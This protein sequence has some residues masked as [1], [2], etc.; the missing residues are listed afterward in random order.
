MAAATR[1]LSD[2]GSFAGTSF[3]NVSAVD[4]LKRTTLQN[5]IRRLAISKATYC[6]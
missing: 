6:Q 4:G 1:A 5:K 3:P 2:F